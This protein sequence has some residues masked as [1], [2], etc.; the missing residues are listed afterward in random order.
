MKFGRS[1]PFGEDCCFPLLPILHIFFQ[2][3]VH[4]PKGMKYRFF[5]GVAMAFVRQKHQSSGGAV[6]FERIV[7][8]L[9]LDWE[10]AGIVIRFAMDQEN[11]SFNLMCK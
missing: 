5:G 10:G 4:F 8:A 1:F 11:R 9:G 6:T 7:I 3:G 2:P